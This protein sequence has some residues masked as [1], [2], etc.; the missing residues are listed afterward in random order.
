MSYKLDF[1]K[2]EY[3]MQCISEA[4]MDACDG[5]FQVQLKLSEAEVNLKALEAEVYLKTREQLIKP[6]E[7][8]V[9]AAVDA[10]DNVI[11]LRKAVAELDTKKSVLTRHF[12]RFHG[13]RRMFTAWFL[14]QSRTGME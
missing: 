7:A 9:S 1:A 11:R 3:T 4:A 6:T 14:A 12:E 13:D 8:M 10:D 5:L 2:P